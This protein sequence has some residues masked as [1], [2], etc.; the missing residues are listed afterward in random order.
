VA[1]MSTKGLNFSSVGSNRPIFP[2]S[3]NLMFE[4][5]TLGSSEWKLFPR[6]VTKMFS[7][8]SMISL[9]SSILLSKAISSFL[10]CSLVLTGGAGLAGV[11]LNKNSVLNLEP[12]SFLILSER[13]SPSLRT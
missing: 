1:D 10:S 11:S 9:L 8:M 12:Q 13:P 2:L 4:E 3:F 5:A 6:L 7:K